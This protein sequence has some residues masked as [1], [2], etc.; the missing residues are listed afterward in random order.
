M[1]RKSYKFTLA[2]EIEAR[3]IRTWLF[4]AIKAAES[5]HGETSLKLG[6]SFCLNAKRRVCF[7]DAGTE[8]G[9]VIAKVFAGF[10]SVVYGDSS[11]VVQVTDE[12]MRSCSNR[13]CPMRA[14]SL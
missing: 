13:D 9:S 2:Q 12:A 4:L 6:F 11:F 1:I 3:D 8:I 7:V 5:I 10:L 14:V